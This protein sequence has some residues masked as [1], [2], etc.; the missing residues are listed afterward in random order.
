[1]LV[2]LTGNFGT[3]KSTVLELF[4]VLGA[5]TVSADE[6]VHRLLGLDA[7]KEAL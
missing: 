1:M 6:V 5:V 2:G 4:R 7:I 3:G